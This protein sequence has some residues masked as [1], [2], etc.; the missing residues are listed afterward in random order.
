MTR[1]VTDIVTE[2]EVLGV[3]GGAAAGIALPADQTAADVPFTPAGDLAATDV[4]A[5]LVELD[6]EKATSG[7]THSAPAASTVTIADAG[8][9]YTGTDV[10]AALQEIGAG[11]GGGGGGGNVT[12]LARADGTHNTTASPTGSNYAAFA[13]PF[14]ATA[15]I[16]SAADIEVDV[17]ATIRSTSGYAWSLAI[18]RDGTKIAATGDFSPVN[19]GSFR[20]VDRNRPAGTYVYEVRAG[21]RAADTLTLKNEIT[22]APVVETTGPSQMSLSSTPVL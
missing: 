14:Q 3:V 7:H 20:F 18:Y 13:T 2:G 12:R 1:R 11:G 19:Q 6:T 22:A 4:Q 15:V 17:Y 5:A 10:E 8:G 21:T 16:A 9:Y